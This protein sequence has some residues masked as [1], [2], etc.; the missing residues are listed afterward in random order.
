MKDPALLWYFNDW[1]GGTQLLN[2]HQKGCYMDLLAVQFNNG[3][4]TLEEIKSLL[5]SD[6]GQW[7]NIQK[8]FAFMDG[9]Y[10]NQRMEDEKSKRSKYTSSRRKNLSPHMEDININ[11]NKDTELPIWLNLKAWTAWEQHRKEKCQKMTPTSVRLQLKL[12]GENKADHVQIIKNSITNGWTGLFALKENVPKKPNKYVEPNY[13]KETNERRNFLA[14]QL[15][16]K[17]N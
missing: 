17:P 14:D 10:F 12:L 9:R 7:P 13:D 2:R 6:F 4:L 5:G 3:P 1:I 16:Y 11:E 15:K 8:K